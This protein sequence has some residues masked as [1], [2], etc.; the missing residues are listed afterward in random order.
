MQQPTPGITI[1]L[2]E[3]KVKEFMAERGNDDSPGSV[4]AA[5]L[6]IAFTMECIE[7]AMEGAEQNSNVDPKHAFA[8]FMT[9]F[10]TAVNAR[11]NSH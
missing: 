9:E 8:V 10:E 6:G 7:A 1:E 3:S 4:R 11:L 2:I 5:F